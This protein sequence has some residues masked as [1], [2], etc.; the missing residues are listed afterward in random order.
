MPRSR[1]LRMTSITSS[2][3]TWFRPGHHLVAQQQLRL[4]RQRLRQ[5]QALAARP[6][7]LVGA[8]VDVAAQADEIEAA[9]APPRAPA[10]SSCGSLA[11]AE[12]RADRDVVEHRQAGK[13]PHDLERAAD[14]EA[15]AAEGRQRRSMRLALEQDVARARRQR[16]ADRG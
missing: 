7:E 6:A 4:H 16:A 14:A 9:R 11:V 12:Q 15:G 3:S 13:R 5:F 2:I 1:T 10:R 8:L